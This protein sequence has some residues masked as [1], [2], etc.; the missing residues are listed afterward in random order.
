MLT[1]FWVLKKG[2]VA[3]V[4][5]LSS[6]FWKTYYIFYSNIQLFFH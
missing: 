3:A 4:F 5:L 6:D 1:A 2:T